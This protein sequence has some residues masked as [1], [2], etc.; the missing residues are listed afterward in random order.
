LVTIPVPADPG[1]MGFSLK[2]QSI[3]LTLG[4]ALGLY[5]SNGVSGTVG[6]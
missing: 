4:N 6:L 5:T 2:G 1:L 3:C